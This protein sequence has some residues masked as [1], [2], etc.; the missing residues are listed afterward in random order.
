ML[1]VSK[2]YSRVYGLISQVKLVFAVS[3]VSLLLMN[4]TA[5]AQI[6]SELIPFWDDREDSSRIVVNHK[7]WQSLLD[8][9]L[10]DTHISGISRFDYYGMSEVDQQ[11]LKDYLDY[12]QLL[13][14]RQLNEAEQKA[15]WINLFNATLVSLIVTNDIKVSSVRSIRSGAF[16][17]FPWTIKSLEISQQRIT[18]DDIVN[19]IIRPIYKDRRMHY[20][21][22]KAAIGSP[23]LQ[24]QAFTGENVEQLLVKAE[25]EYVNH[26]RGLR[27]TGSDVVLSSIYRDYAA[28]FANNRAGIISYLSTI[29]DEPSANNLDQVDEINFNYDWS[30]NTP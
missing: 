1:V 19:G 16:T 11:R 23:N 15:Y 5:S 20:A 29:L 25:K 10:D 8:A 17:P 26:Q 14:P 3:F 7:P 21:L 28:D 12:L 4:G 27:R 22:H 24:K 2:K 13:E 6:E 9:Y 18:L 30:I